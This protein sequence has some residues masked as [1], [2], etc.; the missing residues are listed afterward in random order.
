MAESKR[1][2]QT[3][4]F[5]MRVIISTIGKPPYGI[6]KY[7][8]DIIQLTLNKNQY[9]LKNTKSFVLQVQT[10]TIEPDELQT[11]CDVT[12]LYLSLPIDKGIDVIPQQLSE[13]YEDL[14]TRTKLM[15]MD[16]QQLAELCV[17]ECYFLWDNV[18][19]DL[20]LTSEPI[21]LSI[22]VVLSESYLQNLEKHAIELALTFG[23]APETFCRYVDDPYAQLE[24][25]YLRWNEHH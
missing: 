23:I 22:V 3:K 18:I 7:L 15:L 25:L 5:P 24:F 21:G 10:W 2:K 9:Q 4:N 17:C 20:I 1:I 14:K 19:W 6:S 12:N 8:V 11:L 16:L 13:D